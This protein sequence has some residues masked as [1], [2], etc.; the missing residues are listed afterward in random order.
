ML[1]DTLLRTAEKGLYRVHWSAKILD[2]ATRNLI[3]T[4]RVDDAGAKRLIEQMSVAFPEAIVEGHESLVDAMTNDPKDRHVVA[5]AVRC[6]AQ[7]IVTSN[8]KDFPESALQP[9]GIEAQTP[10][11][12]LCNLLD[13]DQSRVF[14]VITEQAAD[15]HRPPRTVLDVLG[16]LSTTVPKFAQ[17]VRE[18]LPPALGGPPTYTAD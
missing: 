15:L 2:E 16:A 8:I 4:G 13:L 12:F 7:V 3:A 18:L 1:R 17:L 5:A 10:D 14:Q 9:Y 6:H 11:E